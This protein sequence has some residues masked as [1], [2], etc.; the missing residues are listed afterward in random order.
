VKPFVLDQG[1]AGHRGCQLAGWTVLAGAVVLVPIV[2]DAPTVVL[3]SQAAAAAIAVLG[4]ILVTGFSGQVS[5]G[6]GAFMGVGAY[7]TAILVVDHNWPF[8][9]TVPAAALLCFVVGVVV[10]VPALRLQ[11]L[12]L[13]LATLG[14]AVILPNLVN[15]LDS[16]T[17]GSSGKRLGRHRIVAP[18][19]TGLD[20]RADAHVF[21]Y[22]V[23]VA[24]AGV[25]FLV[26]RNMVHSR[27]GRALIAL[28]DNPVGA[29]ASG[30]NLARYK[31]L[32]FGISALYA[33]V[34]GSLFMFTQTIAT[35]SNYSLDRSIALL[36][37]VVIGGLASLPGSVIGGLLVVFLPDWAKN[38]AN[39]TLRDAVYGVLLILIVAVH[40]GGVADLFRLARTRVVRV[41]PRRPDPAPREPRRED[42]G[43]VPVSGG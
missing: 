38:V 7:T 9:A 31:V 41:E 12:Y 11:G 2:Y 26:A 18:G 16:I 5:L 15:K 20:A 30:I 8:F 1:S 21:V 14:L 13:A 39:G 36:T 23:I 42:P 37:G 17:G 19:W 6:H 35:A 43:V 4:L 3:F 40:P 34:A 28:R 24:V 25:L 33:G 27:V 32:A 10:G 29:Q 22:A